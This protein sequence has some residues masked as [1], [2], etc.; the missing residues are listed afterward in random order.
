MMK[1]AMGMS[2]R[3]VWVWRGALPDAQYEPVSVLSL[4][5]PAASSA[6]TVASQAAAE[7][8]QISGP[9]SIYGLLGT[10]FVPNGTAELAIEVATSGADNPGEEGARWIRPGSARWTGEFIGLPNEYGAA[11]LEAARDAPDVA[12]LGAGTLRFDRAA[13]HHVDSN[14]ATYA[15]LARIVVRLLL[16]SAEALSE[17]DLVDFVREAMRY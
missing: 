4:R 7:L 15:R 5:L 1:L 11:V 3:H 14:S 9:R 17:S 16:P 2:S 8:R 10:E 12:H 13:Y 6:S